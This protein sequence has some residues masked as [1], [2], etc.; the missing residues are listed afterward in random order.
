MRLYLYGNQW[1]YQHLKTIYI[2]KGGEEVIAG[3]SLFESQ[4]IFQHLKTIYIKK[5]GEEVIA[6]L[7]S[8]ESQLILN[9]SRDWK[10]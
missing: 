10:F 3:L 9:L 1:C 5:G 4:L 8:F 2:K 7:S 6:G